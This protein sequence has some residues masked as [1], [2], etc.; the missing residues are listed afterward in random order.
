MSAK[1]GG[2][3]IHAVADEYG[4]IEVVELQQKMRSL[5]FGNKTQQAT[6]F[7]YNPVLLV[8][9]YTQAML[10]PLCWQLPERV[11]LLGLG[12]GSMAKYLLH[13]FPHVQI[14]AVELR[15]AVVRIAHDY[16]FLPE[17]HQ[18]LQ[19]HHCAAEDF[20][21]DRHA[22]GRYDLIAVDLFLAARDRDIS[23]GLGEQLDTLAQLMSSTGSIC[24][25][26]IGENPAGH[27]QL[28]ELQRIFPD[29]L[30]MMRVDK[31]NIVLLASNGSMPLYEEIDFTTRE[32]KLALPFRHYFD[33]LTDI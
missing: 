31:S 13:F 32:K 15:P 8:H 30:Y 20:I 33:Q 18:G 12:G 22:A 24:I 11:L 3:L 28:R 6:M 27:P 7:L 29:N 2:Q 17:N 10:T 26:I 23:V 4:P 16:F 25:N 5:H 19:L 14:D 1:Y 21:Q 9:K